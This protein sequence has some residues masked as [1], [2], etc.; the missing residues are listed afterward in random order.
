M[1]ENFVKKS[2]FTETLSM[3][4]VHVVQLSPNMQPF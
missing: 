1:S 4:D 2:F 3:S